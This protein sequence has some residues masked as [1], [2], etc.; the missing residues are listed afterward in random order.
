M[1]PVAEDEPALLVVYADRLEGLRARAL[2]VNCTVLYC[3][4]LYVVGVS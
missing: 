2:V 4:Y 1:P 3:L